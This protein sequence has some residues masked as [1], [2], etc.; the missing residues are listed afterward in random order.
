MKLNPVVIVLL[1]VASCSKPAKK[2][3]T[4][5]NYGGNKENNHYSSLSQIDT[6]NVSQLRPA[7]IFNTGDADTAKYSQI[8]CN[9]IVID[10]VMYF[11]SPTL[12][13][14]AVYAATGQKIWEF[15]PDSLFRNNQFM[16]FVLN[17]NRG[18]TYWT[19][20]K[21][22]KR[23]FYVAS[24]YLHC[25]NA[26]NGQLITSFGDSGLVDLHNDLGREAGDLFV[27]AT[28]PGIIYKDLYILG[29]RVD[30]GAAAAPGHIRAYDVKT[31]KLRWIFHTIPQ[32]GQVGYETWE[33]PNAYK[34]V[35]GANSW[36]GLTI[37]EERGI[38]FAPTGS[39]SYDFYGGKRKGQ[40]LFANCLLALDAGTGKRKWHFQFIHH[41]LWD[42]DLPAPP[43]L[44]TV[45]KEQRNI[46]AVAQV[47]KHGMV[48]LFERETGDPVY[49][50]NE[51]PVDTISELIGE[52]VWPTQPMPTFIKPFVRQTFSINDI[53][54]YLPDTSMARIKKALEGYRYGKMFIPPGKKPHVEFPGFD[55]GAEWG[56]PAYDPETGLFYVNANEMGWVVTM[57]KVKTELTT[58]KE[59]YG[60]A[61]LRLYQKYCTS[62]H[63]P[64][65]KGAGNFPTLTNLQGRY[66]DADI[67]SLL[68]TGRRMMPS[69]NY[70][71][72]EEKEAITNYI[73]DLKENELK[74]F[75]RPSQP[76]DDYRAVPY[77]MEGYN[78]FLS[79]EGYP[80]IG[81]PWGTLTAINLHTGEHVW[82]TTLG[83]Y[84]ELTAK[85][86]PPTG[87]ENYGG[88][89][90]TAGGILF[91]AAAKDS[92]IRAFNKYNGRLLWEYDLP[93]AGFATPSVYEVGGKQFL[94]I[95]CGGGKLRTRSGDA[96]IAFALPNNR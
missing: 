52:K 23:I 44:V 93:A 78:K 22:D 49:P 91:I 67:V 40:N 84:P 1:M 90:V 82:K 38:V 71:T 34:H 46:D 51:V 37:D 20:G 69:F 59:N 86:V 9:P 58:I 41:D 19:D 43:V 94:V 66:R 25:L 7:W 61:G 36:S 64:D 55:G 87:T 33:D 83:E 10:S 79:P 18:V 6:S 21:N 24:S 89:V 75:I 53:N 85:G 50:I 30:E 11:T 47:T 4:W 15:N 8:Q 32:P 96:Y 13:L 62:C 88:P 42:W 29:S 12:K 76:Q 95:A 92:K 39:A 2:Y 63:G 31:G 56:G 54:P 35:G 60:Q 5:E 26:M 68:S 70:I 74:E 17:N 57:N 73:L 28:S 16:H 77:V 72:K 45:K 27:T 48:W 81:P 65:R 14:Y 80:A 3:N